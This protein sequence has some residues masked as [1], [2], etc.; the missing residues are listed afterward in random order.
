V[1]PLEAWAEHVGTMLEGYGSWTL[2]NARDEQGAEPD[3]CYTVGRI[4]RSGSG[5][6]IE[7]Q[8]TALNATKI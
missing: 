4:G 2:E 3:E 5:D 6:G 1:R 8:G 7:A